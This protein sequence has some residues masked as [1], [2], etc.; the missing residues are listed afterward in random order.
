MRLDPIRTFVLTVEL[1]SISAAARALGKSRSQASQWLTQL[2]QEWELE[3]FERGSHKPVLTPKGA[4][5]LEQCR[6]LMHSVQG[7]DQRIAN[8]HRH[9]ESQL[10]LGFDHALD[11]R[12]LFDLA[13][14]LEQYYPNLNLEL[15][16]SFY[17]QLISRITAQQLDIAITSLDQLEPEKYQCQ[18]LGQYDFVL[19][20]HRRHPL[21]QVRH[22]SH[23]HLTGHRQIW[24]RL[25]D[26]AQQSTLRFSEKLW[27]TP[28]YQSA[29]QLTRRQLGWTL[30]PRPLAQP[31]L[32]S[33][34]LVLLDHPQAQSHYPVAAIWPLQQEPG[35]AQQWLLAEAPIFFSNYQDG[36]F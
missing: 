27:L 11:P 10:R 19:C 28:D 29:L 7:L 23:S 14:A 13:Q 17:D 32:D 3:L 4:L 15:E 16:Y 24:A 5:V 6:S 9:E 36:A 25:S 2:E 8:L 18:A 34:E 30:A 1:G 22:L 12:L 21:A 31:L 26:P 35:P 20:C 33:G